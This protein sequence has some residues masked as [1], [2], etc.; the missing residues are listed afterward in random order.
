MKKKMK[1]QVQIKSI[2]ALQLF[3]DV[4]VC[5]FIGNNC[6]TVTNDVRFKRSIKMIINF[7]SLKPILVQFDL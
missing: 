7:R 6:P 1:N 2:D 5:K 4:N 3:T